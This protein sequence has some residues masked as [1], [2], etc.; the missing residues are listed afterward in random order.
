M[1]QAASRLAISP[2]AATARRDAELLLLHT[3]NISRSQLLTHPETPLTP[4]QLEHYF[5]A[6][7]RRAQ[8]EPMQY[9]TGAQEFF[10]LPFQVTPAVLIPRPETEHL[11][12]AAISLARQ[13]QGPLRILDIGTGSGAIAVALSHALP[14]ASIVATDISPAALSIAQ[15]NAEHNGVAGRITFE[16]CDLM[17]TGHIKY[18]MICSNPPYI[19]TG[20]V[21]EPQVAAFEPH[22]ALFAGPTGLEVYQRLIPL[23]AAALCPG[24]NLLLE[25]GYGQSSSIESLLPA[26]DWLKTEFIADLQ[27]IPRVA[28]TQKRHD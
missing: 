7:E 3:C 25:I 27:G 14:Q 15:K 10:G 26:S 16:Q 2:Q 22:T 8:S 4:A 1:G 12:E 18:D 23:A 17:P 6:V 20:E 5:L 28:V 9:I 19:A 21:L 11:V 24:G 13:S